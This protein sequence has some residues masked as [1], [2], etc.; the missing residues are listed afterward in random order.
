MPITTN[1]LM[2][3]AAA[4]RGHERL[5]VARGAAPCYEQGPAFS[6]QRIFG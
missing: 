2:L 5:P 1:Q 6:V 3:V 4:D